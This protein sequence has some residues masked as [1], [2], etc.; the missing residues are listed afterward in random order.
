MYIEQKEQDRVESY[1]FI[2]S[3]L[4]NYQYRDQII[5]DMKNLG[6]EDSFKS[7][8]SINQII[9]GHP[10]EG[11]EKYQSLREN[12]IDQFVDKYLKNK[13]KR[14]NDLKNYHQNKENIYYR[15]TPENKMIRFCLHHHLFDELLHFLGGEK[16]FIIYRGREIVNH[17]KGLD[18]IEFLIK[19]NIISNDDFFNNSDIKEL[20]HH[21]IPH[22]SKI[23]NKFYKGNWDTLFEESKLNIFKSDDLLNLFHRKV[24]SKK[25]FEAFLNVCERHVYS[26]NGDGLN[27]KKL[28]QYLKKNDWLH[29]YY[30]L[31]KFLLNKYYHG[32]D[33]EFKKVMEKHLPD[34]HRQIL[35]INPYANEYEQIA[36]NIELIKRNY[37][38][39]ILPEKEIIPVIQSALKSLMHHVQNQKKYPNKLS[40]TLNPEFNQFIQKEDLKHHVLNTIYDFEIKKTTIHS[41]FVDCM[42]NIYEQTLFFNLNF[43]KLELMK[44]LYEKM[45]KDDHM[46]DIYHIIMDDEEAE[47]FKSPII[48]SYLINMELSPSNDQPK[49]KIKL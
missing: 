1:H 34:M 19:K 28:T 32:K 9:Y 42:K 18:F 12:F 33:E 23:L 4:F 16:K 17:Q 5:E 22:D 29:D 26:Q 40:I 14:K 27:Y 10:F 48:E 38:S 47:E 44:T 11:L 35:K 8:Q 43:N 20:Y 36:S 30:Q 31:S 15:G 46:L 6:L 37:E 41:D 39:N 7:E 13:E 3:N 45:K 24:S 49:R 25:K 2:I 21:Y